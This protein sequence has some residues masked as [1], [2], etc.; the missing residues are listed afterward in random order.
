MGII[1]GKGYLILSFCILVVYAFFYLLNKITVV[2]ELYWTLLPLA[3]ILIII[4]IIKLPNEKEEPNY[5]VSQKVDTRDI[6]D[7]DEDDDLDDD[8][9][10]DLLEERE[11][12]LERTKKEL[13]K[14]K[15]INRRLRKPP[16]K[17]HILKTAK[18]IKRRR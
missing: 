12:E 7:Y 9:D 2:F 10:E 3:I 5:P 8:L 6:D 4:G 18:K 16:E 1:S 11:E 14:Q 13:D 15:R 17:S